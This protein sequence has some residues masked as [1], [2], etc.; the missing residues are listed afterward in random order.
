MD[1]KVPPEWQPASQPQFDR[2]INRF[3]KLVFQNWGEQGTVYLAHHPRR[4]I[5]IKLS[6][7]RLFLP[8]IRGQLPLFNEE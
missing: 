6:D 8:P 5:A 4:Y 2:A 3:P 7:G 1:L